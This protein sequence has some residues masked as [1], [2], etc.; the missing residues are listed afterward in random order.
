MGYGSERGIIPLCCEALFQRIDAETSDT[1]RFNVEV[2]FMEIYNEKVGSPATEVRTGLKRT[3]SAT[4]SIPRT[5]AIS[6]SGNTPRRAST[7]RTCR[8]SSSA[9]MRRSRP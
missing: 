8:S 3:R 4:C 1:L 6:E 5:R 7:S 2:S 9:L